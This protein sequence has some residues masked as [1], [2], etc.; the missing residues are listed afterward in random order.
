MN[1]IKNVGKDFIYC[2]FALVILNGTTQIVIYPYLSKQMGTASFG[3]LL[4]YL[5]VTSIMSCAFGGGANYSRIV[6]SMKG[7]EVLGDYNIFFAFF[8]IL[9]IIVT[10]CS[11]R[12]ISQ[13]TLQDYICL[14]ALILFTTLRYYGDVNY[15]LSLDYRGYLRYYVIITLGYLAGIFTY[16]F[17]HSPMVCLL[18]GETAGFIYVFIKGNIYQKPYFKP[19]PHFS[20]HIVSMCT[21]SM[22][23]LVGTVILNIDRLLI[24]K[25]IDADSVT[26]FYVATLIGKSIALLIN[27]MSSVII[28]YLAKSKQ[29]ISG[30]FFNFLCLAALIGSLACIAGC[31]IVSVVF[32]Q[33]FYPEIYGA[34]KGI[35]LT[36]NAGQV[37]SF[38]AGILMVIIMKIAEEKWQ[39]YMNL[40]YAVVYFMLVIPG[41]YFFS[42]KGIVYAILFANIIRFLIVYI[43][44]RYLLAKK[45]KETA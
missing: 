15:R 1:K 29:D 19:S 36:A 9:N 31:Y 7:E 44:G 8:T 3:I 18:I 20:S 41:I 6:V 2:F 34:I 38:S 39:L 10:F 14:F 27:P 12:I 4:S 30:R 26:Y 16:R 33:I 35:L 32:V 17:H 11:L 22:S 24:L 43:T 40:M 42:L 28:G 21:L 13:V 5:S 25:M 37:F 23:Y 45:Q